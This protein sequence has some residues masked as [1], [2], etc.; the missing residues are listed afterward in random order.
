M[1][2]TGRD[3]AVSLNDLALVLRD[4]GK[5]P[6]AEALQREALE[7]RRK[8]YGNE[9]A[10]VAESMNNLALVLRSESRLAE[11]EKLHRARAGDGPEAV[12]S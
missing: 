11:A 7:L 3:V 1:A 4:Q 12:R 10:E 9:H 5:F 8:L 6:E 2:P